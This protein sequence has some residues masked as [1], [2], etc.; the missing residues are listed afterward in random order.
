MEKGIKLSG[1]VP[2]LGLGDS[3]EKLY[4]NWNYVNLKTEEKSYLNVQ[5]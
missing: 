4:D 2:F 1:L 5:V 3:Q